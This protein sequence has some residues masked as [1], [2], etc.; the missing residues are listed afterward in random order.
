MK[1]NT[2]V[3]L[4]ASPLA[5]HDEATLCFL[6]MDREESQMH[7]GLQPGNEL[8]LEFTTQSLQWTHPSKDFFFFFFWPHPRYTEVPRPEIAVTAW[9]P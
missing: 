7:E 3:L 1:R 5:L 4:N 8:G 6:M 2:K 9:D